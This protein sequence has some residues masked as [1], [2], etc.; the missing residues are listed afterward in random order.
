MSD[1]IIDRL[2]SVVNEFY[3]DEILSYESGNPGLKPLI[4]FI[5]VE[6]QT[7]VNSD[8]GPALLV[9]ALLNAGLNEFTPLAAECHYR[10]SLEKQIS[11]NFKESAENSPVVLISSKEIFAAPCGVMD[12]DNLLLFENR[13][14]KMLLN[15]KIKKITI[16]LEGLNIESDLKQIWLERF[17]MELNA[18][19]IKVILKD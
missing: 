1:V 10:A 13:V 8:K 17:L 9:E 18:L 12:S 3:K 11:D 4:E 6:A 14:F 7:L 2:N 19:K 15:S 16:V 5:S